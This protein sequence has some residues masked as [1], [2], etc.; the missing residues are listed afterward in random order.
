MRLVKSFG[1]VLILVAIAAGL[2]GCS[3]PKEKDVIYKGEVIGSKAG[4]QHFEE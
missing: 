2:G 4:F 3:A 1:W